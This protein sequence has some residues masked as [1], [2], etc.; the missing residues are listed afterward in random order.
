MD[1]TNLNDTRAALLENAAIPPVLC[2]ISDSACDY[3]TSSSTTAFSLWRL[4]RDFR[5]DALVCPLCGTNNNFPREYSAMNENNLP[6]ELQQHAVE[7]TLRQAK[8]LTPFYLFVID[9]CVG[10]A[11]KRDMDDLRNTLLKAINFLPSDATVGVMTFGTAVS[12][13][14]LVDQSGSDLPGKIMTLKGSKSYTSQQVAQ[15]LRLNAPGGAP[16]LKEAGDC[17]P[18]PPGTVPNCFFAKLSDVEVR[19]TELFDG[20]EPD[21]WPVA[22]GFRQRRCTGAALSVASALTDILYPG[23]GGRIMLFLSGPCTEGPGIC[24]DPDQACVMRQHSDIKGDTNEAK[25]WLKSRAFFDELAQK[26]IRNGHCVDAFLNALDQVGYAEMNTCVASTGGTCLLADSYSNPKFVDS[27]RKFFNR[28]AD[29]LLPSVYNAR[30]EV[31]TSAQWKI[32]GAI[33][34]MNSTKKKT[35]SLSTDTEYG[36]GGTTEWLMPSLDPRTHIAFYFEVANTQRPGSYRFVQFTTK[37][38]HYTGEMRLRVT[39]ACHHISSANARI[40][41]FVPS[42]DQYTS[43]VLMARLAS[44]KAEEGHVFDVLRWLDGHLIKLVSRFGSERD[45]P[46]N[47]T[48]APQMSLFPQFMFHLRRSQFLQ[49]FNSSP[50]ETCFCRLWLNRESSQNSLVMIQPALFAYDNSGGPM[51][52]LLD[53]SSVQTSNILLLDT[54]FEVVIHYGE[55]IASWRDSGYH[56]NPE[57]EYFARLLQQPKEEA[58]KI[59]RERYP[60]PRFVECDHHGSQARLLYNVVNPSNTHNQKNEGYGQQQGEI[61][62]TDD[63]SLQTFLERLKEV[64]IRG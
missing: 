32:A 18:Y 35:S 43:A 9:L 55:V 40:E 52:V 7:Y 26:L 39:T 45:K 37:Y 61:V 56:E 62:Y 60:Q 31:Q 48:L 13:H 59:V 22:A 44:F 34:P 8:G 4:F 2:I 47:L 36:V 1:Q 25:Y 29:G 12:V 15:L 11:N 63:A 42:F 53:S 16:N 27:F 5:L 10:S 50:D 46:S 38:Q 23:S 54:Y 41:D 6:L 51:P 14:E 17:H 28:D 49:V 24:V 21:P 30:L 57:Y 3:G 33:G 20:L 58:M 64:A 19:L